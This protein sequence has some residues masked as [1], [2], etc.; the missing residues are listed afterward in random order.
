MKNI[1]INKFREIGSVLDKEEL[2]QNIKSSLK[3]NWM[4][5]MLHLTI[6]PK[7]SLDALN[8]RTG[9]EVSG[10]NFRVSSVS[11]RELQNM[12]VSI[13]WRCKECVHSNRVYFQHMF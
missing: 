11:I 10:F 2:N 9:F 7:D 8:M 12:N 6:P 3:R 5:L 13:S 1:H 4:Q